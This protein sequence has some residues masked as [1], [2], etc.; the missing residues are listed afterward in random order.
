MPP[1][2]LSPPLRLGLPPRIGVPAVAA[3]RTLSLL[4]VLLTF[5]SPPA[6]PVSTPA[7]VMTPTPPIPDFIILAYATDAIVVETVPFDQ[8]THIN[9]AFLIPNPD[10]TFAPLANS[11]KISK[12]IE[13]AHSRGVRVCLSVGGWGW[14]EQFEQMASNPQARAAFVRNLVAILDQFQF[15]GADI[16]WEY[17][18]PGQSA[19]NFLTLMTDLR[20]AMPDKLLTAAVIAYGD[21]TGQGIPSE[22]FALMDFVNIMTYDGPDH[23][24]LE[25]FERG[26]TYWQGRG[27]PPEKTVMGVPFYSR[28]TGIP[29]SKLVRE[30]PAAAQTDSYEY[31][32]ALQ[33]YNGIPTIQAKTRAAMERAGGIM[34]WA[35]DHDATGELSLV[36]AIFQTVRH[37]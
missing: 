34:F 14:D 7:P 28:P 4:A 19:Q 22:S 24:T 26:L 11:W 32:G 13:T 10:G 6:A 35:L 15:D 31:V 29:F 17:P 30:D 37:P 27:L 33:V 23:G 21:E 20:A 16:D 9:Y 5:C 3:A 25:Q 8:L 2:Y 12:L 1:T 36:N 18:D